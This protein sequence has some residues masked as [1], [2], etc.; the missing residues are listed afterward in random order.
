MFAIIDYN[1][2]RSIKTQIVYI[3]KD[4]LCI[5]ANQ[6]S[7]LILSYLLILFFVFFRDDGN[8]NFQLSFGT[9]ILS[10]FSLFIKI[11]ESIQ[12]FLNFFNTCP[13]K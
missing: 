8:K 5:Q 12:S 9:K 7:N 4:Q 1:T 2:P 10:E 11:V 13:L 6:Q 3:Y